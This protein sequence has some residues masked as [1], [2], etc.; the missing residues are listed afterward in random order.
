MIKLGQRRYGP[1]GKDQL[2]VTER[3]KLVTN[4]AARILELARPGSPIAKVVLGH[5]CKFAQ[6]MGDGTGTLAL[7]LHGAL[8]LCSSWLREGKARRQDLQRCVAYIEAVVLREDAVELLGDLRCPA[9]NST[10]KLFFD[11][12]RTF[13]GSNFPPEVCGILSKAC[14]RWLCDNCP[15]QPD[16]NKA[17]ARQPKQFASAALTLRSGGLVKVP[18]ASPSMQEAAGSACSATVERAVALSGVLASTMP[19]ACQ[20]RVVIL[21]DD[22]APLPVRVVM[23]AV[24][25]DRL[26][27][28]LLLATEQLW[29]A[30]VR[31]VLCAAHVHEEWTGSLSQR[32]IAVL[33][34]VDEEELAALEAQ[35]GSTRRIRLGSADGA[36]LKT[37][38]FDVESFRP[39]QKSSEV[40]GSRAYWLLTLSRENHPASCLLLQASSSSLA[41][42]HRLSILRLLLVVLPGFQEPSDIIAGGL[43]FEVGLL[44]LARRRAQS[45]GPGS[46]PSNLAAEVF[47]LE[48]PAKVAH[49]ERLS[50]LLL[51]ASLLEVVE[52][53]IGN[54][55]GCRGATGTLGRSSGRTARLLASAEASELSSLVPGMLPILGRSDLYGFVVAPGIGDCQDSTPRPVETGHLKL[56][57]LRA[58]CS[59]V[60]QL[61][62][63]DPTCLERGHRNGSR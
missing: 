43:A 5:I 52:A 42:E 10:E 7:L 49:L 11:L 53:F 15:P 38:A 25:L 16:S 40:A 41:I 30:G 34:M 24:A 33:H 22:I 35:C 59:L 13:F 46:R 63:L 48:D 23:P 2:V 47:G 62:R 3:Q 32:G 8:R 51:E 28:R 36:S 44:R 55:L 21:D 57:Q 4:S 29:Q 54:L 14:W 50:W 56:Q 9:G 17:Q 27:Q 6:D 60:R 45:H 37:A 26:G 31:L 20:G 18:S 1:C 39:L 61:C 58:M 19:R 12:A